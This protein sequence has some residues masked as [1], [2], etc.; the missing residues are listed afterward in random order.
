MRTRCVRIFLPN[1]FLSRHAAG[2]IVEYEELAMPIIM[3]NTRLF[4]A[5][6][7]SDMR[8]IVER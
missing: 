1:I 8:N 3:H 5:G 7:A 4:L 2:R 6:R